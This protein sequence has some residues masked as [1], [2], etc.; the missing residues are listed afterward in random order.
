MPNMQRKG[1]FLQKLSSGRRTDGQTNTTDRLLYLN[2]TEAGN[3]IASLLT[4]S[5]V[6]RLGR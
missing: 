4:G 6:L 3:D 2:R 5:D 1:H